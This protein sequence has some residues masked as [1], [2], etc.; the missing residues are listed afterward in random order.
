MFSKCYANI[1]M[2]YA[3]FCVYIFKKYF[4]E[5]ILNFLKSEMSHVISFNTEMMRWLVF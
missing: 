4:R 2:M 5:K 1:Y 3:A